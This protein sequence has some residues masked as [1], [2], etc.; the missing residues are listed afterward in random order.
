MLRRC[1]LHVSDLKVSR[2]WCNNLLFLSLVWN[3][4]YP[5]ADGESGFPDRDTV[6]WL[7]EG[8]WSSHRFRPPSIILFDT[9][10]RISLGWGYK[11][12]G[13]ET[14]LFG[15]RTPVGRKDSGGWS[16]HSKSS[17]R[18]FGHC[19]WRKGNHCWKWPYR[20]IGGTSYGKEPGISNI[21]DGNHPYTYFHQMR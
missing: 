18:L 6:S 9:S 7:P 4:P 12:D 11:R 20:T 21:S 13:G 8:S 17:S 2:N 5:L 1:A 14:E 3:N 19:G 15:N 16:V 10:V